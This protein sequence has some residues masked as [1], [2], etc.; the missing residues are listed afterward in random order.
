MNFNPI[1][2]I[3]SD[4]VEKFG[5][6]RQSLMVPEARAVLKLNHDPQFR[7]ALNHLDEFSHIWILFIFH[8]N[9]DGVWTPTTRPPRLDGPNRVGVFASRA[10]RRPNPIGMS[11]VKLERIDYDAK[12]GIE[13]HLSGVD[14]LDGTPVVDI[15]PYIPYADLIQDAHGG[16]AQSEIPQYSV[17]FS[18]ESLKTIEEHSKENPRLKMLLTQVLE[19]D[20]RPTP[21]RAKMPIEDKINEGREFWFRILQ[22]DVQWKIQNQ[23]IYVIQLKCEM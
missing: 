8:Q 7:A 9:A 3:R 11:A 20:P 10:P 23:S 21:Q 17:H 22:F 13:L 1:G 2:T 6:P 5:V 15:K 19:Y 16:W 18:A 12:D 14:L 4:F